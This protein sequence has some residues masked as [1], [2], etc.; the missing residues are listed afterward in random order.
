MRAMFLEFPDDPS[1]YYLDRQYMLGPSLLVAPVFVPLEEESIYYLPA[2]RWTSFFHP[3]RV[4]Q[5]PVW[6]KECIPI[7]EIPVWVRQETL[8]CLGPADQ[9]RPDYDFGR[10]LEVH[11]YQLEDGH[12]VQANIPANKGVSIAGT[13]MVKREGSQLKVTVNGQVGVNVVK[14]IQE[15]H[16]LSEDVS[17]F[18]SKE[19]V[20]VLGS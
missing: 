9:G 1:T 19:I 11:V 14:S 7:N 15:G 20:I 16:V 4:I 18:G 17:T 5:G 13:M 6:V 8:L 2:G 3:G 10:Q 12:S